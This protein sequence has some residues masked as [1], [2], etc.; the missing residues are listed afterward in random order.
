M[1]RRIRF[2]RKVI[3]ALPPCPA[4]HQGKEVE[5]SSEEAPPGLRLVVTK[6]G[7]KS[8]LLRYIVPSPSGGPGLKRS[9]KLGV[10]PGMEPAD[11]IK[12]TMD[13]RARIASGKEAMETITPMT[14]LDHFFMQEYWPNARHLRSSADIEARWRI[15]IAPAFGHLSFAKLRTADILRFHDA[16]RNDLCPATANR[17]LALLKRVCNVAVM[18]EFAERNPCMGVRM[19]AE[20]NIRHRTLSGDELRRFIAALRTETNVVA[21]D[22]FMFALATGARREECLQATWSEMHTE[23]ALWQLPAQRTKTGKAR[24]IPLNS[25]AMDVLAS[26]KAAQNGEYIFQHTDGKPL[27]NPR[28]AWF[29]I[30][31]RAGIVDLRIHDLRRS[32]ATLILNSGGSMTQAGTLLG[33]APGSQLTATRYAFLADQQVVSASQILANVIDAASGAG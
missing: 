11:A 27:A 1:K 28:R 4:E 7:M 3:D 21:A 30:L 6:R 15:H 8:W 22:F 5:Y 18:L 12:A 2:T 19:H 24:V 20:N 31:E 14:T 13:V 33:H 32:A 9:I 16:K 26:R 17:L 23:E 10:Y 25:V 29:R